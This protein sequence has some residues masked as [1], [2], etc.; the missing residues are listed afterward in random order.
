MKFTVH[1]SILMNALTPAMGTVSNKNTITSIEGVLIETLDSGL[2]QIST[3]D[4][5]KGVRATFEP[6]SVE[7][8]GRFIINAQR[9]FQTIRVLPNEEITI[10]IN[11]KLNCEISS[12]KASFSIFASKGEDFPNLPELTSDKGFEI[13]SKT[14]KTIIGKVSHSIAVQDNRAMLMGAFFKINK[15]GM[16]VVS[17][18][19][20]TLSKCNIKCEINSVSH[21]NDDI[22]YKFIIPGHA[23]SELVKILPDGEEDKCLFYLSRK[24]AIINCDSIIFFTRTIDSDYIDYNRIIPKENDIKV[25]INRERILSGLERVN[26]IAEEKIQG[27][28]RSYVKLSSIDDYLT[29]SSASVNGKVTDEMECV[30]TGANIEIGF[31]CRYLINSIRVAE[32]E[33]IKITLKSPTQ[34]IT[35]EK[36]EED[37]DFNYFYMVLPV[38]MNEQNNAN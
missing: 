19:S 8:D 3:Y 13:S 11:D 24:H 21:Q 29:L 36:A 27:S 31:N 17:C 25:I 28:G 23:L 2:I 26:I 32:G 22:D 34:A 9:L 6:S 37:G 12:G 1:K 20:Y 18:D 16:E 14:L 4:M 30:H 7:R 15:E 10:D 35:I 38:R 33:E 5:N